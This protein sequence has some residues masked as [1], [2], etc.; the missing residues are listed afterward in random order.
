MKKLLAA[1]LFLLTYG[2]AFAQ[3]D[4][5][6]IDQHNKY[7]YY[8]VVEQPG[9]TVDTFQNRM[10]YLLKTTFP[11][12]KISN[13]TNLGNISGVGKF[14]VLSGIS[15]IKHQD[16]EIQYAFHIQYRDQRYRYWLTNFV[17][18][19]YKNDDHGNRQLQTRLSVTLEHAE[20]KLGVQK[21]NRYINETAGYS[22]RFGNEVNKYMSRFSKMHIREH[23]KKIS[24]TKTW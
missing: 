20:R 9:L 21:F 5:L 16:G 2:A 7:I 15:L 1:F 19:P 3:K 10:L 23:L 22:I 12:S 14:I 11:E 6:S 17:F 24:I 13:K 8:H 4:S 18:T